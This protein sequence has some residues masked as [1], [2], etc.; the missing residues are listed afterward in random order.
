[1]SESDAASWRERRREA[2]IVHAD[3][4]ERRRLAESARAREL[5][6][7]FVRDARTRGVAPVPLR[8][9]SYDGRHR[10]RTPLRGWY[11]RRDESVAVGTDGEFYVLSV[12]SSLTAALR[13][14]SVPP[15]D[16]PLVIGA[17]GKDGESL[18][19]PV[20]LTR[21]LEGDTGR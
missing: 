10:Y 8:A 21:V 1:M 20:A 3:A 11:L 13:G 12:P 15:R 2:S 4:L 16:P 5:I 14:T 17:G 7:E 19:L 18:D 6:A 9:R